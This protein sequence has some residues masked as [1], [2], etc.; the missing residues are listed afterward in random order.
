VPFAV[1]RQ[2]FS[3]SWTKKIGAVKQGVKGGRYADDI[4]KTYSAIS[5]RPWFFLTI[6]FYDLF[7]KDLSDEL[8]KSVQSN[9][10]GSSNSASVNAAAQYST[11][12]QTTWARP[13]IGSL[14]DFFVPS[15][16]SLSVER[17]ISA[18]A[19]SSDVYQLKLQ[20]GFTAMN[21][22]GAL[23]S[24]KIFS[25]YEQ[26]EFIS[27]FSVTT[28]IPAGALD[29]NA[30]LR[31]TVVF[32]GYT[33]GTFYMKDSNT[34]RTGFDITLTGVDSWNSVLSAAWN[35]NAKV[36]PYRVLIKFFVP[37]FDDSNLRLTR[38][39]TGS[40]AITS[41]PA[42]KNTGGEQSSSGNFRFTVTYNHREEIS[43]ARYVS[44][45]AFLGAALNHDTG[46]KIGSIAVPAGIGGKIVF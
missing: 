34:L 12:Y 39:D 27:S 13:F 30:V 18:A 40:F 33:H 31:N 11:F 36:N 41:A 38:S 23:S 44:I 19:N 22:F 20:T 10:S 16:A 43:V 1:G 24:T 14:I 8:Q 45:F 35:R 2:R 3:F 4:E 5:D 26:D 37:G 46:T 15:N 6:P 42:V 9:S 21:C 7:A 29:S 32:T 28:K 17:D 25:W